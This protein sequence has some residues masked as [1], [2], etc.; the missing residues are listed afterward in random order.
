MLFLLVCCASQS[1]WWMV[2]GVFC[3]CGNM[4]MKCVASSQLSAHHVPSPDR[5]G[6]LTESCAFAFTS[7][8][9]LTSTGGPPYTH[10]YTVFLRNRCFPEKNVLWN[11]TVSGWKAHLLVQRKACT[12]NSTGSEHSVLL[13]V[14]N[15]QC[16]KSNQCFSICLY[17]PKWLQWPGLGQS[18]SPTWGT[19]T[20]LFELAPWFKFVLSASEF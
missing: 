1:A 11:K 3:R 17:F 7:L 19:R 15:I 14:W 5:G 16:F 4:Y 20:E 9:C 6:V 13:H 8:V 10:I 2:C 18:V 12:G